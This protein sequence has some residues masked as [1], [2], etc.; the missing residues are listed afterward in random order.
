MYCSLQ[1]FGEQAK[2]TTQGVLSVVKGLFG[3]TDNMAA[4][5][6][7]ATSSTRASAVTGKTEDGSSGCG[8]Q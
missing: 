7:A 8:V 5:T 3:I 1:T 2:F 4:D 6:E